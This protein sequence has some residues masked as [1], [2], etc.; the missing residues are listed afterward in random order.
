[1]MAPLSRS[2]QSCCYFIIQQVAPLSV[3]LS[4]GT[5]ESA[6]YVPL[7]S[8]GMINAVALHRKALSMVRYYSFSLIS[9]VCLV[10]SPHI[11]YKHQCMQNSSPASLNYND[12]CHI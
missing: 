2:T 7:Y 10:F 4:L 12:D 3:D 8:A 9:R 5:D 1:M 6:L 11:K